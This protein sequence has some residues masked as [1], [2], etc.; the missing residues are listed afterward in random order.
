MDEII[1]ELVNTN[2]WLG[3]DYKNSNYYREYLDKLNEDLKKATF[4]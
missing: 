1:Q 4:N 3:D 2:R